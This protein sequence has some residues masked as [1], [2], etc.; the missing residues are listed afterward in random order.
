[1]YFSPLPFNP[2]PVRPKYPP[3]HPILKHPQHTC[4]RQCERPSFTPIQNIGEI[5]VPYILMF[6]CLGSE[7]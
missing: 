6:V 4:L 5:I 1:M 3:Q 2:V 7:L